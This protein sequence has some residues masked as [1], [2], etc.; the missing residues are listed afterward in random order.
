M[1]YSRWYNNSGSATGAGLNAELGMTIAQTATQIGAGIAAV[2]QQS[3]AAAA[4][5]ARIAACGRKPVI[6]IGRRFRE[7]KEKYRQCVAQASM[8]SA[9][10]FDP[11]TT[12][13]YNPSM[14]PEPPKNN[15]MLV[16]G[17]GVGILVIGTLAYFAFKK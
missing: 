12:G 17:V 2:R 6:G 7:R 14:P 4:R 3:G 1:S 11:K 15:T 13:G 10:A 16:V 9:G 5:Q 8:Q